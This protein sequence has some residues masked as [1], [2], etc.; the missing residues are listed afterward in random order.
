M[1]PARRDRYLAALG[2]VRYRPRPI[3]GAPVV[4]GDQASVPAPAPQTPMTPEGLAALREL[5]PSTPPRPA[6]PSTVPVPRAVNVAAAD[7]RSA[8]VPIEGVPAAAAP[9]DDAPVDEVPVAG[10]CAD[11]VPANESPAEMLPPLR[12]VC[13]RPAADLLVLDAQPPG[14]RPSREQLALLGNILAAIDRQPARLPA[15]E[16]IDWPLLQ[17]GDRSRSAAQEALKL[18]LAGRLAQSPF[19]WLLAM[20][21]PAWQLLTGEADAGQVIAIV[22]G[23]A[24]AILVPGLAEMLADPQCK[25]AT[26]RAIR[27]LAR[28]RE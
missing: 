1:D 17:S 10:V 23:A 11:A 4:A 13:W 5:E 27:F 16:S 25:A 14:G 20:G 24:Q 28:E 19:Q 21:E 22:E 15:A 9:V 26:W 2:I 12:L 8:E 18:F 7:V 3:P 6:P